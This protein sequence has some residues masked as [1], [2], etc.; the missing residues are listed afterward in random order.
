MKRFS[1]ILSALVIAASVFASGESE[2]SKTYEIIVATSGSY[3]WEK[4][5]GYWDTG[6]Y[7]SPQELIFAEF[8]EKHPN[9]KIEY[10]IRDVTQGSLTI[11]SLIN[12]DKF[13]NIWMDA[14]GYFREYL[15]ADDSLALE[16]YM[17][18]SVFMP[19][20]I[21]PY[22]YDGHVYAIPIVNIGTGMAINTD[23][24]DEIGYTLP[25]MEDWT[26]E[27]Y[28]NLAKKLK[29]AGHYIT[30]VFTQEGFTSWMYPWIF[31]FGGELYHDGDYS[32]VAI[33]FC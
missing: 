12:Q 15:N 16:K 7:D 1:L 28:I 4:A 19:S 30:S 3:N 32:K 21:E 25:A 23:M 5:P 26:I 18:V 2:G 10:V 6:G 9:V 13:P 11:D 14:T 27:E 33:N 17:D 22:T 8:E 29:A 20:L 31:A 24:L